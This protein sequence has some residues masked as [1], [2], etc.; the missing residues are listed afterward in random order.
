MILTIRVKPNAKTSEVVSRTGT[1]WSI[2][3]HAPPVEGKA[4]EEL[5]RFLSEELDIPKSRIRITKG[6]GGRVK[7][8]EIQ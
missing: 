3:L 6:T 1:E 7:T 8:V 2:K 4:N 5:I